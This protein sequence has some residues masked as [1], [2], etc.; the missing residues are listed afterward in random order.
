MGLRVGERGGADRATCTNRNP[1]GRSGSTLAHPVRE[2]QTTSAVLHHRGRHPCRTEREGVCRSGSAGVTSPRL[3]WPC[4]SAVH[5]K[6]Q[7][8]RATALPNPTCAHRLRRMGGA[9][10]GA[11]ATA[12]PM[13]RTATTGR[14]HRLRRICGALHFTAAG[15]QPLTPNSW[16][17]DGS[18][19]NRRAARSGP[20]RASARHPPLTHKAPALNPGSPASG[21]WAG[22]GD[23][24]TLELCSS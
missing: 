23:H 21:L 5:G 10:I 24:G 6:P 20:P 22:S 7:R 8:H 1:E 4:C 2:R 3:L 16:A 9:I 11:I 15:A 12:R 19:E 18:C 13:T 14:A 17:R